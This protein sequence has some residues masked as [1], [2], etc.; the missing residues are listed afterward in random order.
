MASL[1]IVNCGGVVVEGPDG[2]LRVEDHSEIRC[3][4]GV[5][6]YVGS[7]EDPV[8]NA[9]ADAPTL[10]AHGLIAAPALVDGH[11]H[12][13]VG[14]VSVVPPAPDW[15]ETY[16]GAGVT[17][18]VSAGELTMPGIRATTLEPAFVTGLAVTAATLFANYESPMRVHAG[19]LLAVPGLTRTDLAHV[20]DAGGRCLK[21]IYY[22]FEGDWA[23][24]VR[25]YVQWAH[26]LGLTVKMHAGG[27]SFRGHS[28]TA[29][30]GLVRTVQ[31]DVLAHAN[32]GPIPMSDDDIRRAIEDTDCAL[33]V[34]LGGNLRLL[35]LIAAALRER[36]E[37][38]RLVV[39][40][41]TPGGNGLMPRGVMQVVAAIA[42]LGGVDPWSAWRCAS[43]ATANVHGISS[44]RLTPTGQADLLLV[45]PVG[46]SSCATASDALQSGELVGVG[47]VV[48]GGRVVRLPGAYLPPPRHLPRF[49][50]Q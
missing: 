14:G 21:F 23:A 42:S 32:G 13:V 1:R 27:T 15:I 7:P 28:V 18:C 24:E 30:A 33:E 31:P 44:G 25:S 45:G 49:V 41:D 43:V 12:P 35:A 50:G 2:A 16:L 38:H 5:V 48:I 40:T 34:I 19:T 11:V 20:R 29:T 36:G 10:D 37:L 39:G 9:A 8:A 46:G 6:T 22:P 47:A 4:N 17:Q 26:E 3:D